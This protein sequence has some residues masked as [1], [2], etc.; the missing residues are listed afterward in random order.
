MQER[1]RVQPSTSGS[2]LTEVR[3]DA[4]A[5]EVAGS[6]GA[7]AR[8]PHVPGATAQP[9]H[10]IGEEREGDRAQE[11]PTKRARPAMAIYRPRGAREEREVWRDSACR[12]PP[13]SH[14]TLSEAPAPAGSASPHAPFAP[15]GSCAQTANEDAMIVEG[16]VA[17]SELRDEGG[18]CAVS[19]SQD[20]ASSPNDAGRGAEGGRGEAGPGHGC[21]EEMVVESDECAVLYSYTSYQIDPTPQVIVINAL[22]STP[23]S[24]SIFR[25][26]Q[27]TPRPRAKTRSLT[28]PD[29]ICSSSTPTPC[30]PLHKRLPLLP[31]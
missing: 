29:P 30:F 17:P 21:K 11:T 15:A 2:S 7:S 26:R 27:P 6:N 12:P 19:S 9:V 10:G 1:K 13:P 16:T 5:A 14:S 3:K 4:C 18:A 25:R 23:K 22:T 8:D 20:T 31:A 28:C 24:I